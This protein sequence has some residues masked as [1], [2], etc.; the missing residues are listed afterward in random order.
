MKIRFIKFSHVEANVFDEFIV[1]Q[2]L[3]QIINAQFILFGQH[4]FLR[5]F[6]SHLNVNINK[7][8]NLLF[9]A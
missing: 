4:T 1:G 3:F 5:L 2:K 9:M 8:Q 6:L 7:G